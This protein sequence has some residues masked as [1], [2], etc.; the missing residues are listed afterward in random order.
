MYMNTIA[1]HLKLKKYTNKNFKKRHTR[2]GQS[3]DVRE[4]RMVFWG[5]WGGGRKG[6]GRCGGCR[7]EEGGWGEG[8][9]YRVGMRRQSREETFM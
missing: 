7:A 6:R 1:W 8:V 2:R 4:W 5:A 3:P 9:W